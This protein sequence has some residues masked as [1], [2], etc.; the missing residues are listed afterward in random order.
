MKKSESEEKKVADAIAIKRVFIEFYNALH[1]DEHASAFFTST[2]QI[3]FLL[4]RQT[5]LLLNLIKALE[6][7]RTEDAKKTFY[8]IAER[9][10]LLGLSPKALFDSIDLYADLLRKHAPF[11]K[12]STINA[13]NQMLK[14]MTAKVYIKGHLDEIIS[15]VN[16]EKQSKTLSKYDIYF[17]ESV[18]NHLKTIKE[19]V[20]ES[21]Q[22][23]IKLSLVTH[24]NCNVFKLAESL[25]S[26]IM[27]YGKE[28]LLLEFKSVHKKVH[29]YTGQL[30]S[31][32]ANQKYREAVHLNQ[33]MINHFYKLI[34]IYF[35]ITLRWKEN[36]ESIIFDFIRSSK[37][38]SKTYLL[39][40][41]PEKSSKLKDK[42]EREIFNYLENNF[43]T[44][45]K[46]AFFDEVGGKISIFLNQSDPQFDLKLDKLLEGLKNLAENLKEKYVSLIGNPVLKIG[47]IDLSSVKKYSLDKEEISEI[48]YLIEE[49]LKQEKTEEVVLI[50]DYTPQIKRFVDLVH[51]NL[52]IKRI[53]LSQ[54]K[55]EEVDLFVQKIFDLKG[56][57]FGIEILGRIKN[58]YNGTY[59]PAGKFVKILEREGVMNEFDRVV[60]K[61]LRE[62]LKE[63]KRISKNIFV[64][65]YPTSLSYE[66]VVSEISQVVKAFKEE[67]LNLFME[68]TEYAI[69]SNRE[70]LQHL[71]SE[72]VFIAFDDFGTGYTNY[73]IVGEIAEVGR[74]KAVKIDG[75]IVRRMLES[76][77]YESMVESIALFSYKVDMLTIYE[78][79]ENEEILN[80]IREIAEY[81]KLKP[82]SILMQGFYLHM[83]TYYKEEIKTEK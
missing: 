41:E 78:F 49:N 5:L 67:N 82:E 26:K 80:R 73:E 42:I 72:N 12:E 66:P 35:Q 45:F 61:K 83:P 2:N 1:E 58:P 40:I 62:N 17:Y 77:I 19:L 54:L 56:R 25:A 31:Y 36:K 71:E 37:S 39:V 47:R 63:I 4:E 57:E 55:K 75:S 3:E 50:V 20:D 14:E 76:K 32:L 24:T 81:L 15:F 9:H 43:F 53:V 29:D 11:M 38:G 70:I 10:Y 68:L 16:R 46:F 51:E 34:N 6:E 48:F 59:I 23:H 64:N 52:E 13:I 30:L 8:K 79:V 27:F 69:V 65:I 60:L 22:N 74:A 7:G 44:D 21:Y 18:Q 28:D 33:E